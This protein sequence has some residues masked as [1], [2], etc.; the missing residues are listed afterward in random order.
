[1]SAAERIAVMEGELEGIDL[2]EVLQVVG[3]GRQY[4][5]VELLPSQAE[6]RASVSPVSAPMVDGMAG[7]VRPVEV[8]DRAAPEVVMMY[9]SAP[10]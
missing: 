3:I 10:G 8:Y 2:V 5:G 6:T 4:T 9:S 7:T 1:M